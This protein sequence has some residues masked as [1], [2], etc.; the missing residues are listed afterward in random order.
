M[1]YIHIIRTELGRTP[2]GGRDT[3]GEWAERK[4]SGM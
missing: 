3:T 1:V 2:R 4:G